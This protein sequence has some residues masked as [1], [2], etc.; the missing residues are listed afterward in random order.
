MR[1]RTHI[2]FVA[3]LL[4]GALLWISGPLSVTPTISAAS[5]SRVYLPNVTAGTTF[6]ATSELRAVD[7]INQQ[8]QANGCPAVTLSRELSI[9]AKQHSQDMAQNNYFSHTGS[10]G[11]NFSQRAR[12]AGYQYFA[13]AEIIAGG[14][15]TPDG[16][17]T[18]WM[19]SAPHRS[20]ILTC[21]NQEIGI[22][23]AASPTSQ[24]G[25]Y[26]TAVFGQR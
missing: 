18:G 3:A 7:L 19:G 26:W 2:G 6:L 8:R 11:S 20:I 23:F 22:G 10:D 17:V 25:Y 16:A 24:W 14:Q 5:P 4:G 15:V 9:A 13:S 21:A 12:A 1:R